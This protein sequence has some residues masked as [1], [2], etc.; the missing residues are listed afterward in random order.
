MAIECKWLT[1]K[2]NWIALL[3]VMVLPAIQANAEEPPVFKNQKER[4]SYGIGVGVARDFKQRGVDLDVDTFL[5]GLRDELSG[6]KLLM[7]EKDLDSTM[8]AYEHDLRLKQKELERIAGEENKKTGEA[9]MAENAKKEGVISLPSGLQ[10]KVLKAGDGKKPVDTDSVLINYRGTLINGTE[11]D[12]SYHAGKPATFSVISVLPGL[13]EALKLMNPGSRWQIFIPSQLGYGDRRVY[14]V[15]P[16]SI[17]IFDVELIS[18]EESAE[19]SETTRGKAPNG[20][21][22]QSH[23]TGQ[24]SPTDISRGAGSVN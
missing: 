6:S 7:T 11:F 15:G 3:G 14:R 19:S 10:Y 24:K 4:I 1:I 12:S 5:K 22:G 8:H 18:I 13:R 2:L 21:E 23:P 16:N 17:L 20:M 9:F